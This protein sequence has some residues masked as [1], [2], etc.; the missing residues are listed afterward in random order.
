M[1]D[2]TDRPAMYVAAGPQGAPPESARRGLV[3][4]DEVFVVWAERH[5][6][7]RLVTAHVRGFCTFEKF[8]ACFNFTFIRQQQVAHSSRWC[9]IENEGTE[10]CRHDADAETVDAMKAAAV[11][12]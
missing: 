7:A 12:C 9:Q 1:I 2:F 5:S 8:G 11:M 6:D 10:W 3:L 4:N